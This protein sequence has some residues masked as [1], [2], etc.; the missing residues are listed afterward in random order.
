MRTA[1]VAVVVL[2]VLC[3]VSHLAAT[4]DTSAR[5]ELLLQDPSLWPGHLE[6]IGSKQ[7]TEAVEE[8]SEWPEPETFFKEY[9]DKSKPVFLKG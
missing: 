9:V 4:T 6:P 7:P 2:C 3:C 1:V 5:E 8:L